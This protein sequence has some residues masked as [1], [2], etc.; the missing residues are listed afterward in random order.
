MPAGAPTKY[1]PEILEKT[2]DYLANYGEQGDEVPQIA[3]LAI[4]LDISRETV[5]AWSA[6]PEKEE[7]AELVGKVMAAQEQKLVNKGLSGEFNAS[8][9]K[10]ALAKHGYADR[11]DNTHDVTVTHDEWIKMMKDADEGK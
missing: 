10:L 1:N 9:T 3:G 2:R 6:D 8:I 4:A 5:Y 7:F 11:T